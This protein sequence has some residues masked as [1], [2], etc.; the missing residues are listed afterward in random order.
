[1]SVPGS[2]LLLSALSIIAKQ[3]VSYL[4]STGRTPNGVGQYVTTYAAP[5]NIK[6]SLQPVKKAL[7]KQYGLDLEKMY[8][9]FYTNTNLVDLARDVSGDRFTFNGYLFQCQSSEDWK[10]IDGW[11]SVTAVRIGVAP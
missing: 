2:T 7:Y 9:T 1:M 5:I 8:F 4:R 3:T 6:G 11:K 10:A